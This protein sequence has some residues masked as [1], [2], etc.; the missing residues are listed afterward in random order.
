M[1]T[2]LGP[3]GTS[4]TPDGPYFASSTDPGGGGSGLPEAGDRRN[5]LIEFEEALNEEDA[6]GGMVVGGFW[7]PAH[8]LKEVDGQVYG[9]PFAPEP[10]K[11]PR[12]V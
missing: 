10:R 12:V 2:T 6:M 4:R 5:F 7:F 9:R 11:H 3:W 8:A 1:T